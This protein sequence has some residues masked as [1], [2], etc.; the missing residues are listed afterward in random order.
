[1]TAKNNM[2]RSVISLAAGVVVLALAGA[3]AA[4]GDDGGDQAVSTT[5][6]PTISQPG[7]QPTLQPT[8]GP[9]PTVDPALEGTQ[10]SRLSSTPSPA[11]FTVETIDGRQI[12]TD[13]AGF[14]LYVFA[15]DVAGDGT[16]ACVQSCAQAWPPLIVEGAI[17][18]SPNLP[19]ELATILRD[20]GT[21]QVTYNGKPLYRFAVDENPG[22]TNGDGVGG[23]W[24]VAV[25]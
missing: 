2:R 3:F 11:E 10:E 13:A 9:R 20:D 5:S 1:M 6:A 24:S 12:V 22:Q 14:T 25:P 18:P 15:N 7:A 16:S 17:E 8:S 21:M 23:T 19:G 4:C